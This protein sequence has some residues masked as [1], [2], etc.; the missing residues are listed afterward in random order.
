MKKKGIERIKQ[1]VDQGINLQKK[2][3]VE[4]I[5]NGSVPIDTLLNRCLSY[6]EKL[7]Y[8]SV[9]SQHR[10]DKH[11]AK[12]LLYNIYSHLQDYRGLERQ[13]YNDKRSVSLDEISKNDSEQ[14][15]ESAY[16]YSGGLGYRRVNWNASYLLSTHGKSNIPFN[17]YWKPPKPRPCK[18][19]SKAEV[20]ELN[21]E[22]REEAQMNDT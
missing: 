2:L 20:A 12:V 21:K 17:P 9:S 10:V 11:K 19:W 7:N 8:T 3:T 4:S 1:L 16:V 13:D 6:I 15:P 5:R 18:V 22:L 14:I